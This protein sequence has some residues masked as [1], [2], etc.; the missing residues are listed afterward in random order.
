MN[1]RSYN[2]YCGLAYALEIL[3]ERWTM[4]VIRE[5]IAGPR[6]F[7]DLFNGLPGISTNL[8]TERLKHLEQQGLIVRQVL[9]PP[10]GSTVYG[11]TDLGRGLEP[12]LLELGKWG[13]QFVP[14]SSEQV[15]LLN[16]GSYALTLKTFFR[17]AQAQFRE[18]YQWHVDG[19]L[20]SVTLDHGQLIVQQGPSQQPA[21][22]LHTTIEHYLQLLQGEIKPELAINQGLVQIQGDPN[23]LTRFLMCCA[24]NPPE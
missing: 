22:I 4:L 3:G 18:S 17:P 8:L 16:I 20:L 7:K 19:E 6:R 12:S 9:A 1:N 23:A 24:I 15:Q 13:S 14:A 10:A 21:I 2:Q 5:L 11:L